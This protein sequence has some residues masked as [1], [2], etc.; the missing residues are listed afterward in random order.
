MLNQYNYIP[1]IDQ[2]MVISLSSIVMLPFVSDPD[3]G[4]DA[5]KQNIYINVMSLVLSNE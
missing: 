5:I 3:K 4:R 2:T 1:Q